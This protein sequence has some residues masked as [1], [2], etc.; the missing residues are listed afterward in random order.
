MKAAVLRE[1]ESLTVEEV[2]V[3]QLRHNEILLKVAYCGICGT[4]PYIYTGRFPI[5]SLPL[6]PGHEFSGKVVEVGENV[7]SVKKGDRVTA[8]IN[9]SCGNCYFCRKGQKLFCPEIKQI[10]VHVS[11]AFADYVKAPE[12]Q[13]YKLP[14][15]ISY[16]QGALVEPLACAV[17]GVERTEIQ[18]G[19][20][21]AIIGA[22]P[23]GLLLLQLAKLQGAYPVIVSELVD[24]R[25]DVAKMLGADIVIDANQKDSVQE[26]KRLTDGRGAD[27]VI[28]AVGSIPTYMQ[29]FRMMR[30]GGHLTTFGAPPA[31]ADI[32]IRPFD[33]YSQELTITGSYAGT[34][35]TWLESIALLSSGKIRADLLITHR[36]PL[37][38]ILEGYHMILEK[39]DG[40]IKV[41]ISPEL[42]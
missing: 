13:V 31:D 12:T 33:I 14:D 7:A 8:D 15:N 24:Y 17:H 29:A 22:G 30:R 39:K 21:V 6:I 2:D 25:M 4:D 37:K 5:P 18:I 41:L 23:M 36:F 9:M 28:E 10:G 1:T 35:H 16:E 11:G 27:Y 32:A 34:Y 20:S 38:Q 26:V 3:P 19:S 40:A 42:G